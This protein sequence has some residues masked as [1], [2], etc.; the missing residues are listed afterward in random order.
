M[1]G[2]AHLPSPLDSSQMEEMQGTF[3]PG[4]GGTFPADFCHG[5]C[6][7]HGILTTVDRS[8]RL[9]LPSGHRF[10]LIWCRNGAR[11]HEQISQGLSDVGQHS[12]ECV[13]SDQGPAVYKTRPG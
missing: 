11:R 8:P 6:R 13:T 1:V 12:K 4:A 10:L 5:D 9:S 2:T 3:P 7:K